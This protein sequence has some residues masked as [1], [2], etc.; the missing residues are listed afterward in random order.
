MSEN[1]KNWWKCLILNKKIS[2]FSEEPE[3][4]NEIF[5]ERHDLI[6]NVTKKTRL[7]PLSREYKFKKVTSGVNICHFWILS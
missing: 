4:L 3:E 2:I 6:L 1:L 5:K 7:H